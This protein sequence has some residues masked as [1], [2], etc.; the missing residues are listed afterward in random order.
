MGRLRVVAGSVIVP[1]LVVS[2]ALSAAWW[3]GARVTADARAP[4]ASALDALPASVEVAGVTD[5]SSIR[6]Q[7]GVEDATLRD[8]ATRS[9]LASSADEMA[10]AYGWSVGDLDWEA[11]GQSAAGGTLV[12]RLSRSVSFDQVEKQLR[13]LG[14]R[15]TDG[16]WELDASGRARIGPELAAVLGVVTTVPRRR[17][18]VAGA[19]VGDVRRALAPI[20]HGAR[21]LLDRRPV[22]DLAAQLT[23]ADVVLLQGGATACAA[24]ALPDDPDVAAQAAAAVA[25]AGRLVRPVWA[26]RAVS[27]DG[28]GQQIRFATAYSSP[29]VAADQADV[30]GALATGPFI[31]RTGQVE[32]S[33]DLTSA[34]AVG[35]VTVLSFDLDPDRGAY[36]SGEGPVLFASCP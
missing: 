25:S 31:G 24:S 32:D 27:D 16:L 2:V 17:L 15:R 3:G 28:S 5:W 23:G 13:A 21:S 12:A 33:L 35:A 4:L 9:V 34:S 1:L 8:L 30:R 6:E 18:I 10:G 14:Y 20:R 19:E 11:Y 22:A 29:V 36:L 26:G 7:V